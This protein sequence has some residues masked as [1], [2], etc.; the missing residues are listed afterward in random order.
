M[1]VIHIS[2][3]CKIYFSVYSVYESKTSQQPTVLLYHMT[4]LF[5]AVKR[6]INIYYF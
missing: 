6:E 4:K 3:I 5:I 2:E 1:W